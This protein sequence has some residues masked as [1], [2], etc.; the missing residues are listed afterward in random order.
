MVWG[1]VRTE[2]E[3]DGAGGG[4]G[5]DAV[6]MWVGFDGWMGDSAGSRGGGD[7]CV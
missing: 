1:G 5:G 6:A 2:M 4:R 3:V 7:F